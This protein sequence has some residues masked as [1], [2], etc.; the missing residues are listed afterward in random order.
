MNELAIRKRPM[1]SDQLTQDQRDSVG[2]FFLRLKTTDPG[3]YDR[4]MPDEK[5]EAIVKREYASHV[6]NYRRDK[7]DQGISDWHAFRQSG[8]PDYRFLN[9]DRV[10]GLISG[11]ARSMALYKPFQ[12]SLPESKSEKEARKKRG[13]EHVQRLRNILE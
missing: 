1:G 7:I 8:D 11:A 9:I 2:Y 6:M 12:P 3:E 5:T 13:R 10:V 4:L